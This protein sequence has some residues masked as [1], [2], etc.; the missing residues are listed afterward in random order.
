M[1]MTKTKLTEP[2]AAAES[3]IASRRRFLMGAGTILLAPGILLTARPALSVEAGRQRWGI[4]IE[5]A[6]CTSQCTACLTACA[7][8]H[9]LTGHNRPATDPHWI[10]KIQL[11]DKNTGHMSNVPIMCQHCGN[12][13]CVNVC[14]TGASMHRKDG[15]VLVDKHICIGCRYCI[16]ACPFKARGFVHESVTDQ[17]PE[18]P[19]GKGS[20]EGCTMC[21]HLIDKGQ[22]PACVDA[23]A[24]SGNR[25]MLFGD[26]ND[27]TSDIA[28]RVVSLG[29]SALRR[30]LR[31][32]P[33]IR[34][35][36]VNL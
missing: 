21:A 26:L 28:K 31:T 5:T 29:G 20:A 22:L 34:Y 14:P 6:R 3:T 30:D 23:C 13:Q 2:G 33:G 11:T 9:G 27:P 15:I 19:R 10:R 35:L 18:S 8:E 32:D 7:K 4:L 24:K 16:T 25:A 12:A 17:R 36:G 1:S